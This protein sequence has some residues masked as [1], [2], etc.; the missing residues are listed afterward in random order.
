MVVNQGSGVVIAPGEQT[1]TIGDFNYGDRRV[2]PIAEERH[3]ED[4][5]PY[6]P[7]RTPETGPILAG[8]I[9]KVFAKFR[10]EDKWVLQS[11]TVVEDVLYE[12][13]DKNDHPDFLL[14]I[15]NWIINLE[16][17]RTKSLFEPA[18][19]DEICAAVKPLPQA[20]ES[21]VRDL[22][23]RFFQY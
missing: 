9:A 10:R 18:D 23:Q 5:P 7:D 11:G 16:C 14:Y 4:Q 19:W 1:V 22:M 8:D 15:H 6:T 21:V 12:A 2:T 3:G 13:A 17:A 20:P